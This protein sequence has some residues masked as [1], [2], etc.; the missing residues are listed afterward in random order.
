MHLQCADN[1][2]LSYIPHTI[3]KINIFH[4]EKYQNHKVKI[5]LNS[6]ALYN[7]CTQGL[8]KKYYK[9]YNNLLLVNIYTIYIYVVT[10]KYVVDNTDVWSILINQIDI[11]NC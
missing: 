5:L 3:L 7:I 8:C 1:L 2:F 11:L 6:E 10:N 9:E 4:I